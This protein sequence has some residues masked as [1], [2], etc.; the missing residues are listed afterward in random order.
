[1]ELKI[2]NKITLTILI[3]P[4]TGASSAKMSYITSFQK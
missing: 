4:T 1:M 3:I 2:D